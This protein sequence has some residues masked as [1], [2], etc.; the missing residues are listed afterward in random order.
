MRWGVLECGSMGVWDPHIGWSQGLR[1][2]KGEKNA[3]GAGGQGLKALADAEKCPQALD[4]V[5]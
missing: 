1:S 2:R 3:K 4:V 5:G